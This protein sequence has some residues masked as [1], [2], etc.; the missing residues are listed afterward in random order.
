MNKRLHYPSVLFYIKCL[1]PEYLT[2]KREVKNINDI[3]SEELRQKGIQGIIFD[4]DNTIRR[5]ERAYVDKKVEKSLRRL[6][7]DFRCCI[8]SNTN[9]ERMRNLEKYFGIHAI[10]TEFEKP[11]LGAFFQALNYLKTDAYNTA[12]VGDRLL[13]DIAGGNIAGLLTIKV[14][15]LERGSEPFSQ[16]LARAFENLVYSFYKI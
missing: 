13:T 1:K 6:T 10:Q 7:R 16:T 4:A 5:Y 8:L 9:P 14:N 15:P 3:S 12:M 11:L 2:P